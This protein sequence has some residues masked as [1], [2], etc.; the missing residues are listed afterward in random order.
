MNVINAALENKVKNVLA[1][2]DKACNPAN[3]YGATKLAADTIVSATNLK[4]KIVL[5][6][7]L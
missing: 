3:L 6:F 1:L 7:L 5:N 2:S 4:I